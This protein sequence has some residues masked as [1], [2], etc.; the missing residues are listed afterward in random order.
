MLKEMNKIIF[1]KHLILSVEELQRIKDIKFGEYRFLI[2]AVKEKDK[3]LNSTDDFM[4]L[5]ILNQE[6]LEGKYLKVEEVVNVLGGIMPL[7]PIWIELSFVGLDSDYAVLQLN[8][9]M[10]FRKPSLLRN[11]ETGHAPF[12]VV[13]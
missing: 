2:N 3:P 10:R 8:C 6:N 1:K 4:R 13:E 11:D 7:V 9:S 5:N 12:K